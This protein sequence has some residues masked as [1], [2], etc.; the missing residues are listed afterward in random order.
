MRY[1]SLFSG[2]EAASVAWGNLGWTPLAFAEVDPFACAVLAHRFPNVPNLGDVCGIDWEEF[3]E[4]YGAVDVLIGG[5]PCQSFSIAGS[6]EGLKGESRLM[7]EYIRAVRDLV[8]ASGGGSPRYIVWENVPGC[9]SSNKGRDFGCLLDE[10]EDCG[11]FV[12]WRTLDSQFARV[13]DGASGRFRGPVPQ[14]RRR[15]YLVG[16]LGGPSAADIL[17]ERTSMRGDFE[18]G[19]E[20][21]KAVARYAGESPACGGCAGFKWFAG[22][23]ARSIGYEVGTSPTLS[24]SDSHAP[25]VLTP[26]DAQNPIV[27]NT[28]NTGANGSNY[29]CDGVSYTLDRTNS[30]AVC[31]QGSMIGRSDNAGPQGSGVNI[32]TSFTLN[33][34]DRHAVAFEQNQRGEVRLNNGDGSVAGA[35]SR[36]PSQA[37]GQGLSLVCMESAQAKASIAVDSCSPTLNASHE[38]PIIAISDDNAKASIETNLCGT[39][40]VGGGSPWIAAVDRAVYTVRRLTPTE[41]ERLQAFPDGWTDISGCDVDGVTNRVASALKYSPGSRS[42][43]LLK[44]KVASWSRKTPD[45]PRYKAIGNSMT[46]YVVNVIGRRIQAYDELHYDEVGQ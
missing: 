39:L 15:V 30:N 46:T 34:T 41:C 27:M 2:V 43:D 20:A 9:L 40:K 42:Y 31:I 25:A 10:L 17:F 11:Y 19:R 28:A 4:R 18:T 29:N 24:V 8:R 23:G 36:N 26:F 1:V 33:T 21:R 13:F 22:S 44:N 6:R 45:S 3:N 12:A 7:F 14:R 16:S 5:S 32:D 37:K 35:L 38:Q